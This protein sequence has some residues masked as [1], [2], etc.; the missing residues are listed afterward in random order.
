[1]FAS[2]AAVVLAGAQHEENLRRGMNNRDLTGQAKVI[3]MERYMLSADQG[4]GV[5]TRVSQ[6]L[7]RKLVDIARDVSDSGVVASVP[8]RGF[9]LRRTGQAL[10][11]GS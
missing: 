11:H 10:A 2:H 1:M 8:R 5:L 9:R 6:E 4:V 7:N 3:L